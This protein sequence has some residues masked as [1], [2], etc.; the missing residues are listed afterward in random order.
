MSN[1]ASEATTEQKVHNQATGEAAEQKVQ[2]NIQTLSNLFEISNLAHLDHKTRKTLFGAMVSCRCCDRHNRTKPTLTEY[3]HCIYAEFPR[4]M[5]GIN[6]CKCSCRHYARILAKINW[7]KWNNL[8]RLFATGQIKKAE[9]RT[10]KELLD[11]YCFQALVIRHCC[12]PHG[13]ETLPHIKAFESF[14]I[15][16]DIHVYYYYMYTEIESF[17]CQETHEEAHSYLVEKRS[18]QRMEERRAYEMLCEY[19]GDEGDE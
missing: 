14:L 18:I 15:E 12:L 13:G 3:E 4:S 2:L 11:S 6:P 1:S 17:G 16:R 7:Q 19:E 8:A 9:L 10:P 5:K